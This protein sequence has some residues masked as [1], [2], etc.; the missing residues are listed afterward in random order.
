MAL[1]YFNHRNVVFFPAVVIRC[2]WNKFGDFFRIVFLWLVSPLQY[3]CDGRGS[4]VEGE[5]TQPQI[6][7]S[8]TEAPGILIYSSIFQLFLFLHGLQISWWTKTR[9]VG[10][11]CMACS[12]TLGWLNSKP[13]ELF[14]TKALAERCSEQSTSRRASRGSMTCSPV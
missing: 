6:D 8:V 3:C 13:G 9:G 1:I 12:T 10:F 11:G 7:L 4:S 5:P 14:G 2:T